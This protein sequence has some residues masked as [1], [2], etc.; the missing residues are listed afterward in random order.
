[1]DIRKLVTNTYFCYVLALLDVFNFREKFMNI[2]KH[3]EQLRRK[4]FELQEMIDLNQSFVGQNCV[5]A[6]ES[7]FKSNFIKVKFIG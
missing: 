2:E 1:M 6:I 4:H 7:I 5:K 3:L